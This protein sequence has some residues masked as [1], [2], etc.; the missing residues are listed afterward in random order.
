[1]Y[2]GQSKRLAL[3]QQGRTHERPSG[4]VSVTNIFAGPIEKLPGLVQ[5]KT[6]ENERKSSP[7]GERPNPDK[8]KLGRPDY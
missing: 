5:S 1:M 3:I 2:H 4:L 6:S 8:L 7:Q